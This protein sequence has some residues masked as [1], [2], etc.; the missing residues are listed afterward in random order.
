VDN[1]IRAARSTDVDRLVALWPEPSPPRGGLGP[2]VSA[3]LLRSA[4]DK[5]CTMVEA[6]LPDDLGER[7][8]WARLGFSDGAARLERPA[9]KGRAAARQR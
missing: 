3:D 7:D 2:P 5:G 6:A 4:R 1:L 8:R 9:A